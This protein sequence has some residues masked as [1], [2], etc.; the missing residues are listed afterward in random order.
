M[1]IKFI[2]N[3]F[4]LIFIF[5]IV[6]IFSSMGFSEEKN[7]F[8]TF[9][10]NALRA[11]IEQNYEDVLTN[12]REA[13]LMMRNLAPLKSEALLF[14]DTIDMFASYVPR[15]DAIFSPGETFLVYFQPGNY[16]LL[17]KGNVWEINLKEYFKIVDEEGKIVKEMLS[18]LEFHVTL[19]SP[20]TTGLYFRNSDF[21]PNKEGKYTLVIIL[22]DLIK[23]KT[24]KVELPFE[25]KKVKK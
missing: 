9:L 20:L 8:R 17:K 19:Y 1:N 6:F 5:S 22:K 16:S 2:R 14:C 3:K 18:P 7:T 25:V 23:G 12:L 11:Y 4:L 24:L 21:T 15:K 13:S 10:N